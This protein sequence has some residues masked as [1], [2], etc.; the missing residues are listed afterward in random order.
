MMGGKIWA[1]SEA[2]TGSTFHFTAQFHVLTPRKLKVQEPDLAFLKE[3]QL[4]FLMVDPS[5]SNR[6]IL[7]DILSSWGFSHQE[8]ADANEAL[9]QMEKAVKENNPFHLVIVNAQLPD[10]DGFEMSRRMKENPLLIGIKIIMLTSIG[11]IG[12]AAR[13]VEAGISAYLLKPIKRSDLFD[14]IMN[15]QKPTGVKEPAPQPG[16]VTTHSIREERQRQKSLILLAEDNTENRELYTSMLE[17]GGY[18]VIAVENGSKVLDI[19]EKH[20]FDLILMDVSMPVMDGVQATRIIREKEKASGGVSHIPI[21]AMTGR[22]TVEDQQQCEEAGMDIHIAKPFT[23][24]TLIDSLEQLIKEKPSGVNTIPDLPFNVLVAEDNKEN[25]EVVAVLLEK[26][27]VQYTFAHNGKVALEK[28]EKD[29]YDLLLLD[30]QMPVMDGL[31]TL[32]QI[33]ETGKHNNLYVIALTAHA[34]KGDSEKYINAGCDDY[35]S[36]PIDKMQFRKKISELIEK[37]LG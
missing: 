17:K 14:A 20:P 3:Q 6:V 16:L 31:A 10:M 7:R 37:K 26:M 21:I 24:K 18:S 36:K 22:A 1:E 25:Q 27:G 4:R 28:L 12:D 32:K 29:R 9:I 13:A 2:G 11:M 35:I 34:I 5:A 8:A 33:Q 23:F 19:F 30:M 15:L